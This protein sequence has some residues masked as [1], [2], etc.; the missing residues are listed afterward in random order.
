M[1]EVGGAGAAGSAAG[2]AREKPD[3][4]WLR[5]TADGTLALA[6]PRCVMCFEDVATDAPFATNS[7]PL[8]HAMH[9]RCASGMGRGDLRRCPQCMHADNVVRVHTFSTDAGSPAVRDCF[10]CE[11]RARIVP[12]LSARCGVPEL[13]GLCAVCWDRREQGGDYARLF[14]E[15]LDS[16]ADAVFGITDAIVRRT[17]LHYIYGVLHAEKEHDEI[18]AAFR[19]Y[20]PLGLLEFMSLSV[21]RALRARPHQ[22]GG[23]ARGSPQPP[24]LARAVQYLYL[25]TLTYD[26]HR[27]NELAY[28]LPAG[29]ASR[30]VSIFDH[31]RHSLLSGEAE[32]VD[33]ARVFE[34]LAPPPARPMRPRRQRALERDVPAELPTGPPPPLPT[35]LPP[36]PS[37][38]PPTGPPPSIRAPAAA[39]ETS[40]RPSGARR[41]PPPLRNTTTARDAG[42]TS[43]WRTSADWH[44]A[45]NRYEALLERDREERTAA[46]AASAEEIRRRT[47]EWLARRRGTS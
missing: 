29:A 17:K 33:Y 11:G 8:R 28:F 13:L 31:Q 5:V 20:A 46:R 32:L 23:G 4:S 6:N 16:S 15:T 3:G 24:A 30:G 22:P 44:A 7:C 36:P 27:P 41:P 37:G 42:G 19:D 1:T 35:T 40:R 12:G 21:Y 18:V 10:W 38:P 47:S 2:R 43:R 14:A 26:G 45:R 39:S 9:L 25:A 34:P